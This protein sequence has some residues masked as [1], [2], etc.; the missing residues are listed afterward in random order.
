MTTGET[1]VDETQA[2][3]RGKNDIQKESIH[4]YPRLQ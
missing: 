2:G 3:E 4:C 1:Y